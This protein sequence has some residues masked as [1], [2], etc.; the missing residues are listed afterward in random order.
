MG[1]RGEICWCGFTVDWDN[2]DHPNK[3]YDDHISEVLAQK[4]TKMTD[5]RDRLVQALGK[6]E[7]VSFVIDDADGQQSTMVRNNTE[8]A[9]IAADVVID[10]LYDLSRNDDFVLSVRRAGFIDRLGRP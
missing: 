5:L 1:K 7:L 3:Q 4:R 9:M 6:A 10:L 2:P 8:A